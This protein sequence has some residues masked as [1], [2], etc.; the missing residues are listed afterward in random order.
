MRIKRTD[1][2]FRGFWSIPLLACLLVS[3]TAAQVPDKVVEMDILP[4]TSRLVTGQSTRLAIRLEIAP[5][6]HINSNQPPDEMLVPTELELSAD[7]GVTFGQLRFPRAE[8]KS[9]SFSETPLAVFEGTVLVFGSLS[10]PPDFNQ[11][12]V[13]LTARLRFQACNDQ[14]CLP[15]REVTASLVLPVA[16]EGEGVE[17]IN[18]AIF[19]AAPGGET[20]PPA[21]EAE[22]ELV[23]TIEQR[24]MLVAFL[25]IFLSGLALN[26][27]P[28]V[29]PLIPITISY[30]GGQVGGKK[31]SLLLYALLYVLGMAITYS[32]LG[33]VAALTGS[34]LGGWLQNPAVLVF[35]ALVMVA[36]ALSMFGLYEIRVPARLSNFAGQSKGGYLGSLFMGLTVG[37]V[38]AP[39]IGPFVLALLTYVGEKGDP[40]LGFWMFFV[41]SLGL[42]LPYLLLGV[43]SGSVNRLPRSGA[44]MIW[45]RKIFGF[46]LL[47]VAIYFL[48]PLMHSDLWYYSLLA[49]TFLVGGIYLA[50]VDPN[51]APGPAFTLVRNLVGIVFLLLSVFFWTSSV[52]A[53]VNEQVIQLTSQMQA[54]GAQVEAIAWKPYSTAELE[55]ARA[56]GK[57][58]F[59]DFFADWCIPCK[60]LDKFT[61]TDPEVIEQSRNFVMLKA[62]LTSF[63]SPEVKAL[64]D[65]YR[66]RGV[67]TLVML[68]PTGREVPGTRIVG[69]VEADVLLQAMNRALQAAGTVSPGE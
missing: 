47:A 63:N 56:Q 45:V 44:W 12:S 25:V 8:Q 39:C 19:A 42:G 43:F 7:P 11:D 2:W 16:R 3:L 68:D 6:W 36:L 32:A 57:P 27:T 35:I 17:K 69:F 53:Y 14:L 59:I 21:S 41:L 52:E 28:C 34:M 62:D 48:S 22:S 50:W 54:G 31:G 20:G 49:V 65:Q 29:Y 10:L 60:E 46:L 55:R 13:H 67:P 9:F 30:F 66:I 4:E 37:I 51:Q 24:G 38:A 18:Q 23:Q 5:G 40:V 1:Q 61:F 64:R 15:P 58:V 26:L 33:V